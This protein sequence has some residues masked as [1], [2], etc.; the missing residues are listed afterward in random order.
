MTWE[1][2][3]SGQPCRG[4]GRG[5]VGARERKPILLRT[6]EEAEATE[7]ED[8]EFRA[9]HPNCATMTWAYGSTGV[10]HCSEC[11]PMP[12]LSP[13]QVKT[14]ARIVVES[15]QQQDR[16]AADTERRWRAT[17]DTAER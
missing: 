4:C 12:P 7:R 9:M 14:I 16:D 17:S 3:I 1:E 6:P 10:T 5:F 15:L 13:D 11:C 2:F 8:A